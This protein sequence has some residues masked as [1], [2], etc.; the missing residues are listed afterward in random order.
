MHQLHRR[1]FPALN[2]SFRLLW[3][4]VERKTQAV[5]GDHDR[6]LA[7]LL[8]CLIGRINQLYAVTVIKFPCFVVVDISE[9]A[10]MRLRIDR[11]RLRHGFPTTSLIMGQPRRVKHINRLPTELIEQAIWHE[12]RRR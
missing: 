4:K 12:Q 10:E 9:K 2:I 11:R 3:T 5:F 1:G 7:L 6:Y 8:M